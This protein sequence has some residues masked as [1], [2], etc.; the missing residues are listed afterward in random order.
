[1]TTESIN[2]QSDWQLEAPAIAWGNVLLFLSVLL[3]YP[4]VVW[5]ATN[6]DIS[7]GFAA[8]FCTWFCY[9]CFSVVHDAGHGSVVQAGHP[10]KWLESLIGWAA[11]VALIVAPY[12][13]FQRIHERHHAYTNDPARDP[14]HFVFG[15][16]WYHVL[17][18]VYWM[19]LRYLYLSYIELKNVPQFRATLWSTLVYFTLVWGT[20][21]LL[22][23]QGYV[24][25]VGYFVALPMT[26]TLLI[27]VLFF[28][29]IPHHPHKQLNRMHNS[30]IYPSKLLNLLLFGQ[31]YHL[32]HHLYP[33][34]PWYRYQSLYFRI[35]PSL[36]AQNAPIE[37]IWGASD[38]PFMQAPSLRWWHHSSVH[39]VMRVGAI[40]RIS[41][42]AVMVSFLLPPGTRFNY[43]AGQYVMVSKW[44]D[45]EQLQRCYSLCESPEQGALKIAVKRLADG[46]M[47]QYINASLQVGGEL[48][49]QGPFGDFVYRPLFANIT[50]FAAGSG[51]TPIKAILERALQQ[52][53]GQIRLLYLN[54]QRD[55]VMF[56]TQLQELQESHSKRLKIDW[57]YSAEEAHREQ[58]VERLKVAL[59][60]DINDA[61]YLCGPQTLVS[62]L[63]D[64]IQQQ[65]TSAS[66]VFTEQFTSTAAVARGERHRVSLTLQDG[67]KHQIE[68]AENQTLLQAAQQ[69]KVS[70]VFACEQGSC[71]SC[72]L[73][74]E[75][76]QMQAID[77]PLPTLSQQEQQQGHTLACQCY[78][79]SAMVVRE[80]Q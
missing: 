52:T 69:Q 25:E 78:P 73:K 53:T 43:Q 66:R 80:L 74:V 15:D 56:K 39:Q 13:M 49:V 79:R 76:G 26:L 77:R 6:G 51:I 54:R 23:S 38:K 34:V 50:L 48:I 45:G 14:D 40:E 10:G 75:Q 59:C 1:M 63:K 31:N 28:D 57:Y 46:K 36:R 47:S 37:T 62:N 55:S 20:L 35:E 12:R 64:H 21:A 4:A 41:P 68:V 42:D 65:G 2:Y 8:L 60:A 32:V 30:R 7:Y 58:L 5:A 27:L 72:R 19:P 17:A 9:A 3:G 22:L 24:A 67:T 61:C 16:R 70:M 33:R 71:G 18:S 29:Y 11:S 44:L